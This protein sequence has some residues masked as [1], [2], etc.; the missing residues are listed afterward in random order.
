M[1]GTLTV[2]KLPFSREFFQWASGVFLKSSRRPKIIRKIPK[3][4]RIRSVLI[5]PDKPDTIKAEH[6]PDAA[7]KMNAFFSINPFFIWPKREP[8]AVGRKYNRF[9]T[10]AS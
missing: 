10:L 2:Q 6:T 8:E 4:R 1:N 9:I 3:S 7:V 5:F